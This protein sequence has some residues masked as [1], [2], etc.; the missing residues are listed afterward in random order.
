MKNPVTEKVLAE[1]GATEI[2]LPKQIRDLSVAMFMRLK[3]A[4]YNDETVLEAF[5]FITG[6]QPDDHPAKVVFGMVDKASAEVYTF[7][8]TL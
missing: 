6:E 5:T 8:K 3:Q 7:G 2:K 4:D 1:A